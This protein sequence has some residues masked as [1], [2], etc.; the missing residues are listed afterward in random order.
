MCGR[1]A[2]AEE[3]N[4]LLRQYGAVADKE[5]ELYPSWNVKPTTQVPAIFR[6]DK[7]PDV[8]KL[9]TARWSLVPIW[10]K[11]LTLKF[12]TFNAR[13]ESVFEKSTFK[14]SARN[15]RCIIPAS[16]Y[17]EWR[18][19]GKTKT[20]FYIHR[21][22]ESQLISFAGLY[23]WWHEPGAGDDQGWHLTCTMLTRDAVPH[24]KEIHDRLP[25]M[26]TESEFDQWLDPTFNADQSY[27]TAVSEAGS[28]VYQDLRWREVA[29]LRGD[30]PDLILPV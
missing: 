9:G 26:L 29:P 23:S 22:D 12:P 17:Y 21:S 24:T 3:K 18:T 10:A 14:A 16:G 4:D 20:P 19:E 28:P 11:E 8:T 15:R 30:S 7:T 27:L 1:Y 13:S 25:V 2:I 5:L 6:P